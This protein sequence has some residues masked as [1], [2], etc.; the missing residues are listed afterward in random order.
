MNQQITPAQNDVNAITQWGFLGTALW[1]LV[2]ITI[3][4]ILQ[5]VTISFFALRGKH[6]FTDKQFMDILTSAQGNGGILSVSTF[7][8]TIVC[9]ALIAGIIKLKRGSSLT[10]YIA[11]RPVPM[12]EF[13]KW[14]GFLAVFI[15][16]SDLLSIFLGR[17]VVPE[18]VAT[19]YASTNPVW[20]IWIALIVAAPLFE[21]TFFRGF[22]LK[23][24]TSSFFG[25]VGAIVLT[26]A[27]WAIIHIQYDAYNVAMIF[28]LGLMFGAARIQTGSLL[29]PLAMHALANFVSTAEAAFLGWRS[30]T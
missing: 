2:I 5:V 8:T 29:V 25:P 16:A 15:A 9:C 7:V 28:C 27:I 26:A 10:S 11:I 1:G 17:P 23:G 3:F 14:L 30:I 20:I 21:E 24:F 12:K 13:L 19:M 18:F 6:N 22:L 4:I